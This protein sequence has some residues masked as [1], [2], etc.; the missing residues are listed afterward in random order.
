MLKAKLSQSLLKTFLLT[1]FAYALA[2]CSSGPRVNGGDPSTLSNSAPTS[3]TSTG[4]N[5]QYGPPLATEQSKPSYGPEPANIKPLT[6]VFGSGMAR[7][8]AQVGVLRVLQENKIPIGAIYGAEVGGLIAAI[9]A[10]DSNINHFEWNLLRFKEDVFLAN[11][12]LIG[13]L[14]NQNQE[15]TGDASKLDEALKDTFAQKDIG[16]AKLPLSIEVQL[17]GAGSPEVLKSGSL[18]QAVR[19]ALAAPGLFTSAT[20]NGRPVLAASGRSAVTYLCITARAQNGSPIILIDTAP[21][22]SDPSAADLVIRPDLE[23]I[24]F[25]DFAKRTE[26]AVRGKTATEAM[27]PDLKKWAGLQTQDQGAQAK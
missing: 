26:I 11:P 17:R 14:F 13:S 3:G 9:Y 18:K 12:S 20:W 10:V 6:L 19:A 23:G 2:S 25:F 16:D 15:Y 21:T 1:L 7:S 22:A 27:L 4:G 5:E 24:G 8:F